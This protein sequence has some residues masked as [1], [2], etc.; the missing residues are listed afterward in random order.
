MCIYSLHI[1]SSLR[2]Q[3]II[4][5]SPRE[6]LQ[7]AFLAIE[8]HLSVKSGSINV[9]KVETGEENLRLR[10]YLT[11]CREVYS[12]RLAQWQRESRAA[13]GARK[14]MERKPEP[15]REKIFESLR[16]CSSGSQGHRLEERERAKVEAR[17]LE[18]LRLKKMNESQQGKE[19]ATAE[20]VPSTRLSSST[21][22][23]P[24]ASVVPKQPPSLYPGSKGSFHISHDNLRSLA[25]SRHQ[26]H[27]LPISDNASGNTNPSPFTNPSQR[28]NQSTQHL[29]RSRS[30]EQ[31]STFDQA[32]LSLSQP[33]GSSFLTSG[34][35]PSL[36]PSHASALGLSKSMDISHNRVV[37]QDK[38]LVKTVF[39]SSKVALEKPARRPLSPTSPLPPSTSHPST[40]P[41]SPLPQSS[42]PPPSTSS[43]TSP[44]PPSTSTPTSP[45]PS[46]TSTFAN[47]PTFVP[48][49]GKFP[50]KFPPYPP[51]E[52]TTSQISD[53]QDR[54]SLLS[55]QLLYEKADVYTR[56][57]RAGI[58]PSKHCLYNTEVLFDIPTLYLKATNV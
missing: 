51:P 55:N 29:H 13:M 17:S 46:S 43:P 14:A 20:V 37:H 27:S 50:R 36:P 24:S 38:P 40:S 56:L 54:I 57:H 26:P 5:G 25:P 35:L 42:I 52:S 53:I 31:N 39:V 3:D 23:L 21:D 2:K 28:L 45:L 49:G 41:T 18:G 48:P 4:S 1:L 44:L 16:T 58:P 19:E 33:H 15:S 22:N 10:S 7:V 8:K 30:S 47:Q 9:T 12:R 34:L 11:A 32:S 6:R